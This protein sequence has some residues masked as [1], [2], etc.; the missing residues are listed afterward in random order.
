MNQLG[1]NEV[2]VAENHRFW[3]DTWQ[4]YWKPVLRL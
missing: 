2:E 4:A 1:I 3:L